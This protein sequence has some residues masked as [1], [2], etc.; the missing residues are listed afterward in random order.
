MVLAPFVY[1]V[2]GKAEQNVWFPLRV[3][4]CNA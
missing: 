1:R 4:Q 3:L 2:L